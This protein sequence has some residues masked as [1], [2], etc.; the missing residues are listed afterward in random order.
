MSIEV[1]FFL[2]LSA[3]FCYWRG[4]IA[5]TEYNVRQEVRKVLEH[6]PVNVTV[7][8]QGDSFLAYF[9]HNKEFL[10]QSDSY[11]SLIAKLNEMFPGKRLIVAVEGA[12]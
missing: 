5:G 6:L 9:F 11:E 7:E 2:I 1:I 3:A 8:R 10:A 12:I 4:F